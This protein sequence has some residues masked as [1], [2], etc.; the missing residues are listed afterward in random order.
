MQQALTD[1]ITS[2]FPEQI[3]AKIISWYDSMNICYN[4]LVM[5]AKAFDSE[6][7]PR[8]NTQATT[9]A[10]IL[11]QLTIFT[12]IIDAGYGFSRYE[13]EQASNAR[14]IDLQAIADNRKYRMETPKALYPSK[15]S[16]RIR[17]DHSRGNKW[18]PS[19]YD[20]TH[21]DDVDFHAFATTPKRSPNTH[22][23]EIHVSL[24][25]RHSISALTV[26]RDPEWMMSADRHN[27]Y[28]RAYEEPLENLPFVYK[29]SAT[30]GHTPKWKS[31]S[32]R[33]RGRFENGEIVLSDEESGD[34]YGGNTEMMRHDMIGLAQR[35]KNSHTSPD[36][37]LRRP[38]GSS[39]KE[40]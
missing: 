36:K 9:I 26:S 18:S 20:E 12:W 32:G 38:S 14:G 33:V 8:Y 5:L 10:G 39:I 24:P 4:D 11:G 23:N 37:I 25:V 27:R 22:T 7:M 35:Y 6:T 13:Y 3:R 34:D 16:P 29:K 1:D 19:V 21:D 31:S 28:P 40:G 2:C 15:I 17:H 30:F